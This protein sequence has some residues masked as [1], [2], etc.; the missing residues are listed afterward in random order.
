MID[1]KASGGGVPRLYAGRAV[2]LATMMSLAGCAAAPP[3]R[4]AVTE[5][6]VAYDA[7]TSSLPAARLDQ[8]WLL[9]GDAQLGELVDVALTRGFSV[10]EAFA[11]LE[12]ARAVRSGALTGFGLQGDMQASGEVRRARNL[13]AN[14]DIA[15]LPEG[16][17]LGDILSPGTTKTAN[18]SL[19]ISWELDLFGRRGAASSAADADLAAARFNYEAARAMLAADVARALFDA[20]GLAS[21]LED[22]RAAEQ[23]QRRLGAMVRERAA[24]GLAA[25]SDVDRAE[26]DLAQAE[27]VTTDLVAALDASRRALLVLTGSGT[28]PLSA[29]AISAANV[30]VPDVPASI[31]GDLLVRRP[32]VR[33]ADARLTSAT[34]HVRLAELAFYPTITPQLSFGYTAQSGGL[35]TTNLFGAIGGAIVAPIFDRARLGAE[36]QGA[37]ARAEQAVL[38][39]ERVVHTAY[40]EVDKALVRLAADRRRVAMLEDGLAR[41]QRAFD[42]ALIRYERGLSDLDQ[43]LDAER[44]F[45]AARTA[46]SAARVDALLRSVETFQAL[47]G[48][49]AVPLGVQPARESE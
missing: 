33:E 18:A 42:A 29:L 1:E 15:G 39:Y 19:P 31:P 11:R 48:G 7:A 2:L 4:M 34:G 17:S 40:S 37:S 27:A 47:G 3:V 14:D 12:E 21:Q 45:R 13:G 24:R 44:A 5:L 41:A 26:S 16:I 9:Y 36:L 38:A 25:Q 20:R 46:L 49:W 32:D 43:T 30:T 10:R 35:G 23:I 8:W 22:A 28:A 6:P